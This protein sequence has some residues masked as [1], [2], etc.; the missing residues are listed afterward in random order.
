MTGRKDAFQKAMN[1]GHSA[2][3]DQEWEKAGAHYRAALEAQP[4]NP[5]ALTSLGLALYEL[6]D[7]PAALACYQQAAAH[8]PD[9]PTPQEKMARIFERTG[10]LNEAMTASLQA[11]ELHLKARSAEKAI[12]NWN[13]VL[14]LQP[15]HPG[16]RT[17]LAAVYER[18]GRKE[19][20]VTE[21]I[22][23]ASM[24]QRAGDMPRAFK[25]IDYALKMAPE[26]Q[27]ARMAMTVLRSNRSL[28][29]PARPAGG[30]GPVRMARV[31]EM[32]GAS[33]GQPAADG[34]ALDPTGEARQRAMVQLAGLL[35]DQAD[36]TA[37]PTRS[38]GLSALT[39]GFTPGETSESGDRT[40][41][42]L[43]LSQ[44]IDSQTLG[45][46][47]Q[48]VVELEHA[49]QLGLRQPAA[50]FDLGL[51]LKD[52]DP[53]RALRHLQQAVRAPDYALASHLLSAQIYAK[54]EQWS[55][56][57]VAALQALGLADAALAPDDQ[58]E[59]LL[60]QYEALVDS[61]A[62]GDPAGLQ[63]LYTS[64]M[65]NLDRPDW[66]ANL[67]EARQHLPPQPEGSPPA[68][69]AEMVLE[70]RSGM[71]VEAM[72]HVR[73][74][75]AKKQIRSALEEALYALQFAPTY[76]PLHVLIGELFQQDGRTGEA[77]QKFQV[78][79]DLYSVR[80]DASRAVRMLRRISQLAPAD[81]AVRQ[82]IID[83]LVA[84]E[85]VEEALQAYASLAEL[86]YQI[87][88]LEKARQVYL[89]ALK[90]AQKSK[91]N[92]TW[93]VNLLTRVA[94]MDMQRL[95]LRQ[96]LRVYEQ[97]RS[98]QPEN[99]AAR[100]QIVN[101]NLRL[102]L[103]S[104]AVKELDD[105]ITMLEGANRR[106]QAIHFVLELL[107]DHA[108]R[109]DLRRRLADLY[110]RSG[111]VAEAVTQL[112]AA[113]DAAARTGKDYEAINLLEMIVSLN[114]PNASAYRSALET[115]RRTMLRK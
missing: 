20:A 97:V 25:L 114:P 60:A 19:Q 66:R 96:A 88:E 8:M 24:S 74:L 7:F 63:A 110:L 4:G 111:Q 83:M 31:R 98:I 14:S 59:A 113:A 23:L 92:R 10:R 95:N 69:V 86:Y 53:D 94:D 21:Y 99:T 40:R 1:L 115:M 70:T 11:A 81:L 71:V 15:E 84:Q 54:N 18:M 41:I 90:I 55:E 27:E 47:A 29:R 32:E 68:P 107:E 112:D 48:A 22:A 106:H 87:A 78:V 33:A 38:R 51:M 64:V 85:K 17:R 61:T 34:T 46:D 44:A 109:T 6:Q 50:S 56:A 76:L 73:K 93:G 58:A 75:A 49:L 72:A 36:E 43:H 101:L 9:D 28:P 13:R 102:G 91:D 100:A 12:E 103:E 82:R 16:V 37:A 79:A 62:A 52:S 108:G 5:Q 89:E 26:N 67:R 42:T 80:G 65:A 77:V 3:W 35:F 45:E 39:R 105:T 2:A 104:A 30:T 57:A